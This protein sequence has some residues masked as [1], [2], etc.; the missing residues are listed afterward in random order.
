MML[1]R[2]VSLHLLVGY[3]NDDG[4]SSLDAHIAGRLDDL[5]KYRLASKH[6]DVYTLSRF[7][8]AIGAVLAVLY[9]V[10]SVD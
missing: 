9:R 5:V 6:L 4:A 10:M 3:S 1:N 8:G 7:G 2:S